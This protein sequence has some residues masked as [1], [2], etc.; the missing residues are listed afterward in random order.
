MSREQ[1]FQE[2]LKKYNPFLFPK[3]SSYLRLEDTSTPSV[4]LN[5]VRNNL[6][7]E[8]SEFKKQCNITRLLLVV[9][10]TKVK[11][12]EYEYRGFTTKT[13]I[14]AIS[15]EDPETLE[16]KLEDMHEHLLIIE[17]HTY[18]MSMFMGSLKSIQGGHFE[19]RIE[20]GKNDTESQRSFR[21]KYNEKDFPGFHIM[22][23]NDYGYIGDT[24]NECCCCT[25]FLKAGPKSFPPILYSVAD[26]SQRKKSSYV[27]NG[28]I[29]REVPI[30][31]LQLSVLK[32]LK[33]D[34]E[35]IQGPPGQAL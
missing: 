20:V 31:K 12:N 10:K 9:K 16:S 1:K 25:N 2:L 33:S 4:Y 15:G 29:S 22:Y 21:K 8:F 19:G 34:I 7:F 23:I 30:N 32:G 11:S 6:L 24:I 14:I 3:P 17:G 13:E 26:P 27:V 28:E 5:T 18:I 35:G